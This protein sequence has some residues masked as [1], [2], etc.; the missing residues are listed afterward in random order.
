MRVMNLEHSIHYLLKDR[1]Q[2]D[3]PRYQAIAQAV[4]DAIGAGQ[5]IA[6]EKLPPQRTLART[7]GVTVG[8]VS[9]AYA[10][11]E[12][13]GH[14][15]SR[16]GDGTYVREALALAAA[17]ASQGAPVAPDATG[18]IDLAHNVIGMAR[19]TDALAEALRDI[20]ADPAALARALEYTPEAG[21]ERHRLALGRWLRRFGV[22]GDS[23]RITLTNGAQ[24]ALASVF[25]VLAAPGD[26]VL[27]ES[28]CYP[29][30]TALAHQ[31]R[32]QL[33]SL[34]LDAEGIVPDALERACR[35][36]DARML[37]CVPTLHNPTTATMG[38]ARRRAIADIARRHHLRIVEDIVPAPALEA[39]PPALAALLP[40]Q[41]FLVGSFS[42]T[43]A[44]GLRAGLIY[45]PQAW[46][47]KFAAVIRANCWM[48]TPLP[49][50]VVTRWLETGAL[51]A[52]LAAQRQECAA[53]QALAARHLGDVAHQAHPHSHHLWL[54]LPPPWRTGECVDMLRRKG[55]AVK[56]VDAFIAGRV[57]AQPAV[58]LCLTA[59]RTREALEA[60][61]RIVA[62]TLADG[63]EGYLASA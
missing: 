45:A 40:E 36:F 58:R 12:R 56:P 32:L 39:P 33:V 2:A 52:L 21:A 51:D 37:F 35:A 18:T 47:G 14:V 16:V 49:L 7:L 42:K 46:S 29:G 13:G 3:V 1:A 48:A 28:L 27:C 6:G 5:L 59:P 25:R 8:T 57:P 60:G 34:E 19:Q 63:P 31:M 9:R 62:Q 30:L 55:V 15:M 43:V 50:E 23:A 11:L 44:P 54:P 26:V 22:P 38:E 10:A 4:T 20:A 61:L 17:E 41:V 24:H 53:R